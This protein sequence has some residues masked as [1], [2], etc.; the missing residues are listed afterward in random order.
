MI[1]ACKFCFECLITCENKWADLFSI[2]NSLSDL[3]IQF[4]STTKSVVQKVGYLEQKQK[5]R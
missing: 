5:Q 2:S 3:Q 1:T 4:K